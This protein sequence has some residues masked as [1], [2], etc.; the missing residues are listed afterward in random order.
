MDG[1]DAREGRNGG[2]EGR[3][4]REGRNGGVEGIEARRLLEIRGGVDK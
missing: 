2:V 3:D 4:A 1:G